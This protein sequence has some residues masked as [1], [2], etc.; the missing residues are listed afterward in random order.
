[1]E[2]DGP[3]TSVA[4]GSYPSPTSGVAA[5]RNYSTTEVRGGGQERQAATTQK[6]R[7]EISLIQG[8][9][10]QLQEA[11]GLAE[12]GEVAEARLRDKVQRLEVS[13]FANIFGFLP[14]LCPLIPGYILVA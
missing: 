8:K 14:V 5:E 3:C 7:E 10:Q 9:E 11:R 12:G 1:M 13:A 6:G 4:K 2:G